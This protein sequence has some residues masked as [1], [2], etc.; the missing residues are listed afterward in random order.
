MPIKCEVHL[1][2]TDLL[3]MYDEKDG[4]DHSVSSITS[5]MEMTGEQDKRSAMSVWSQYSIDAPIEDEYDRKIA[6]P[7]SQDSSYYSFS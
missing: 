4:A 7:P 6:Q 2:D 5:T 3:Y 1:Y